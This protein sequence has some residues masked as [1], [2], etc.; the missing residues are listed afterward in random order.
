[1]SQKEL[2]YI[3]DIYNHESLLVNVLYDTMESIDDEK[4]INMFDKHIEG[5]NN[6]MKKFEKLLGDCHE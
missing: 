3:E 2:N 4:Y 6:L 5:Y 1:M